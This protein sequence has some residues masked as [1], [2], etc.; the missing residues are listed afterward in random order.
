[1]L[2]S[3]GLCMFVLQHCEQ[4]LRQVSMTLSTT[5]TTTSHHTFPSCPQAVLS[6]AMISENS[7]TVCVTVNYFPYLV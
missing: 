6:A 7:P 1:M 2:G 4:D 5:T 3:R